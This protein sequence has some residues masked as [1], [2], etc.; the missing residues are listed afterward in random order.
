MQRCKM[1]IRAY[2]IK[3]SILLTNR[4]CLLL[5]FKTTKCPP[6]TQSTFVRVAYLITLAVRKLDR[7]GL[8]DD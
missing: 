6:S 4:F 5:Y 7:N 1:R 3:R 2:K 8:F